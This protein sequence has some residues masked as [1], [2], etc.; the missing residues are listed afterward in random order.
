LDTILEAT[1]GE[2]LL[3]EILRP[4]GEWFKVQGVVAHHT[5][6]LG[7]GVRF[8]NLNAQQ[9][10]FVLSLL[11]NGKARSST[12]E[13]ERDGDQNDNPGDLQHPHALDFTS[14]VM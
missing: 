14:S 2:A 10:D 4:D 8:V 13:L 11:P 1:V 5:P 7:F 12:P 3:L 6:R 9:R